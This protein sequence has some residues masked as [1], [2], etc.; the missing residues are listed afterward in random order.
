MICSGGVLWSGGA[1]PDES[2]E[3]LSTLADVPAPVSTMELWTSCLR[4]AAD[5]LVDAGD[6][7]G[8]SLCSWPLARSVVNGPGVPCSAKA[9]L[10]V[11]DDE[12]DLRFM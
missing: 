1:G 3:L 2:E 12:R 11:G 5:F 7:P 9:R 4:R 6:A 10:F 8:K